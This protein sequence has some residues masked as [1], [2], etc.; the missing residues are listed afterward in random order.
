MEKPRVG[1][2]EDQPSS[3]SRMVEGDSGWRLSN[4]RVKLD[5]E[6]LKVRF[7]PRGYDNH[8]GEAGVKKGTAKERKPLLADEQGE[9]RLSGNLP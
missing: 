5:K 1:G 9:G 2:E 8:E 4:V 7:E 6:I 3:K